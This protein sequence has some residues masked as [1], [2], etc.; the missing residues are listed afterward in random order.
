MSKLSFTKALASHPELK[1]LIAHANKEHKEVEDYLKDLSKI[2]TENK[3][4]LEKIGELKHAVTH[5]VNQEE[6]EI[7]PQAK[8]IL[9]A[10]KTQT[11][12]EK[13]KEQKQSL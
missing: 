11:M 10:E 1:E 4:W 9:S 5:H 12:V 13:M 2:P 7:F 6:K 8:K 3:Q